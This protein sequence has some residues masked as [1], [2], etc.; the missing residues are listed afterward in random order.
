MASSTS[1]TSDSGGDLSASSPAERPR[2]PSAR[3]L[4]QRPRPM[5]R[6]SSSSMSSRRPASA[7]SAV[8]RRS[9][10]DGVVS[11][12]GMVVGHDDRRGAGP[13]GVAIDLADADRR[14]GQVA[15]VHRP[16]RGDDV[17]GVEQQ[18]AQL[19]ALERAHGIDERL[20]DV[21]RRADQS[22]GR[23][24]SFAPGA[25][26]A[27]RPPTGAARHL[28]PRRPARSS[29]GCARATSAQRAEPIDRAAA[30]SG[31]RV[32]PPPRRMA[33]SSSSL[34]GVGA[35]P[36]AG[37]ESPRLP[38]GVDRCRMGVGRVVMAATVSRTPFIGGLPAAY[39]TAESG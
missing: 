6:W 16:L 15:A 2:A 13:D 29:A 39:Q 24:A 12:L 7:S 5:T 32:G 18:D 11:P 25:A 23:P 9:S 30:T 27:R 8:M 36:F 33:S 22:T 1:P 21:G 17:L 10:P 14:A 28:M 38:G 26:R 37:D 20:G 34:A 4:T 19:L 3:R 31:E 35:E